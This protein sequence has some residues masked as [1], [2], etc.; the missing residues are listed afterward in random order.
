MICK[1]YDNYA[2]KYDKF[3]GNGKNAKKYAKY[4]KYA[5]HAESMQKTASA[6]PTMLMRPRRGL[7]PW[8]LFRVFS[9]VTL[10]WL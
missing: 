10:C 4:A 7:L 3:A 2:N 5:D 1:K 6:L 8:S 9:R